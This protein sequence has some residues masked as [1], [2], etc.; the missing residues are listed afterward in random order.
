[1]GG[2]PA[3]HLKASAAS[4]TA[5]PLVGRRHPPPS[6]LAEAGRGG[7]RERVAGVWKAG[8]IHPPAEP[9]AAGRAPGRAPPRPAPPLPC[10]R[11]LRPGRAGPG[12]SRDRGLEP[13]PCLGLG[14]RGGTW[15][16]GF[17]AGT[18]GLNSGPGSPSS[19]CPPQSR[20]PG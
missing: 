13:E 17:R 2:A 8:D 5:P 1:M 4:P 15:G 11:G 20:T 7:G 16:L 6:P 3:G 10:D 14:L 18:W 9:H 19:P 12:R